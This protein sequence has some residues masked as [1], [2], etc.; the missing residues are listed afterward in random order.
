[1]YDLGTLI[2]AAAVLVAILG[3]LFWAQFTERA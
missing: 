1:M 3:S 2:I